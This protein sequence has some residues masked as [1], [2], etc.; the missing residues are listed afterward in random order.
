MSLLHLAA[1]TLEQI[2]VVSLYLVSLLE[3]P[4]SHL[5]LIFWSFLRNSGR[6]LQ[7]A[8]VHCGV[9]ICSVLC[10]SDLC[11]ACL[12]QVSMLNREPLVPSI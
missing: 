8:H 2:L 9:V 1:A 11:G 6:F 12:P 5:F 10:G 3:S 4:L 7:L